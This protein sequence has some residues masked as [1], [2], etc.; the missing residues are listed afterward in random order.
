M[1]G[2]W[3]IEDDT[4]KGKWV[5]EDAP[6]S[7]AG[8]SMRQGLGNLAAGAV[9]GAGS[10]GATILAP[11]DIA[12]DAISGKGLSLESNRERR[13]DMDSALGN[14]G[15][16]T[17]SWMYQG[18]E[19]AGEIA[20]TAGAGGL[21]AKPLQAFAASRYGA[22]IEPLLNGGVKA[23]QTGG[24]R[25]GEL[26]GVGGAAARV[27]GGAA[28][29]AGAA[30][31]ANPD[32]ALSGALIGGALPGAV[33]LAGMGGNLA[34]SATAGITK[35]T[36]GMMSGV[37][38]E[39]VGTAYRAGKSGGTNF[40][41]NMRGNVPMDDVLASAKG[42]LSQMR[43]DRGA[44]YRDGM[45]NIASDKA[46]IDFAPI[47]K[48]MSSLQSMGSFKGQA[49]NKNAS[50]TVDEIVSKV[51]E[52]KA[53]DPAEFHTPEGLDALKQ[54]IGD[55][56]DSAQFGTPGRKA[57]D[58]AYNAVKSQITAQAPTYAKVMKEYSEASATLSEI[59][60]ALSLKPNASVDT[61]MRKLQSLMRNNV[62]TNYGNRLE[63]AKQLEQ[64][65]ADILPGIAGQAMNSW[66]PRGLQGL[67]STGL[68]GASAFANPGALAL[69]PAT[70]P[71]LI[72][73]AAYGLGAMNRGIG[74][75]FRAVGGRAQGLLGGA[76]NSQITR[77]GL[78]PILT[79]APILAANQR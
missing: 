54:A 62:N 8:A 31:L 61:S 13:K 4:P 17:D 14:M 27:V 23:L 20:G 43:V 57:A 73:E 12:K 9:R 19:L 64:N 35:N 44:K 18:G 76:A 3:V 60:R 56:R 42:A 65:G 75:G 2:Q 37:G 45:T 38:G 77:E 59:E 50:G 49:I 51:N 39:S 52:W 15:A 26:S 33:K 67:S 70:S 71:R 40:I 69:L 1:A 22:G 63:L 48:A 25:V 72:G 58:T 7:T 79:T 10:I 29:G 24:F 30:G 47:D 11:W 66:T 28:S 36:L 6:A 46:V 78:L 32:D 16:E 68:V 74:N 53:L 34:R 5:I 55:I 41:D 21:L